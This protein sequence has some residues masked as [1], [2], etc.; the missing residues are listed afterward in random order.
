MGSEDT[1]H[2]SGFSTAKQ[3]SNTTWQRPFENQHNITHQ[4]VNEKEKVEMGI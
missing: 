2:G 1:R 3:M 4:H